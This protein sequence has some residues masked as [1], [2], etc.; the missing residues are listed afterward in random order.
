MIKM[1]RLIKRA[2]KGGNA[3]IGYKKSI[4]FIKMNKPKTVIIANNI[5][6]HFRKELEHNCKIMKIKIRVFKGSSKELGVICG[7]PY[8]ISTIVIKG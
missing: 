3:I 1:E 5:P 8:P 4:K 7:K 2:I 6:E